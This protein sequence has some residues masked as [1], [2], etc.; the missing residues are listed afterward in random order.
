M[1]I[2][3]SKNIILL[4]PYKQQ[5]LQLISDYKETSGIWMAD[6]KIFSEHNTGYGIKEDSKLAKELLYN[7][8]GNPVIK[9]DGRPGW[10][11][12]FPKTKSLRNFHI[13]SGMISL[14]KTWEEDKNAI[15][16]DE[17]SENAKEMILL[18]SELWDNKIMKDYKIIW[19][20]FLV[21]DKARERIVSKEDLK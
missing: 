4:D 14:S 12:Y 21:K 17:S 16:S 11:I 2:A 19:A 15:I 18:L 7:F 8:F 6:I 5:F 10:L 13:W 1:N 9:H 3:L 20:P